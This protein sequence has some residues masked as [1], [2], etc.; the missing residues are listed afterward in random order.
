MK[1]TRLAFLGS[2]IAIAITAITGLQS[3]ANKQVTNYF[4]R[5]SSGATKSVSHSTPDCS[6]PNNQCTVTT[7]TS[8]HPI[9]HLL[10]QDINLTQVAGNQI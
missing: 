5:S 1:K 2:G 6:K 9:S 10:W 4:Y 8:G 7:S 3:F